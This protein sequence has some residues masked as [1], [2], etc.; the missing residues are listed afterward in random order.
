MGKAVLVK[1]MPAP[2]QHR[3]GRPLKYPEMGTMEVGHSLVITELDDLNLRRLRST[4]SQMK[5]R[6]FTIA[7]LEDGRV[8]V[9]RTE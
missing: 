8:Q 3:G 2:A 6:K 7:R 1:D 9:Y 4:A 5:G